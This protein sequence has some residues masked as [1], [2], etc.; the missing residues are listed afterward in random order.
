MSTS[1]FLK[2]N[3]NTP[4]TFFSVKGVNI[5]IEVYQSD[6]WSALNLTSSVKIISSRQDFY[7]TE[8]N[9]E[10]SKVFS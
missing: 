2:W 3:K 7:Q 4:F 5:K 1:E 6:F 8:Q 9:K 10:G